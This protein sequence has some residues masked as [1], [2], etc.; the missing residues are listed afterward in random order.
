MIS[1]DIKA[2]EEVVTEELKN[3]DP[4]LVQAAMHL[5]NAGG[6]RLRPIMVLL[7]A[8]ATRED[9]VSHKGHQLLAMAVEI[10]HTATL[11]HDDIIDE[12]T[13]RRGLP[14]VNRKWGMRTSILTGDF[15]LARSCYYISV[16][17]KIRLNTIFSQMVM[18]MCNGEM[19]QLERRH[20]SKISYDEYLEQVRCKTAL[21]MAV[22]C[23]GAAI[24]NDAS[25]AEEKALYT[26][27]HDLGIAFQIMDDILDFSVSEK[28]M[29]KSAQ[30]DLAQGQVT[31]PTYYA[32]KSSQYAQE[33]HEM[34]A[35]KMNRE[36]DLAR[37]FEI[38]YESDGVKR[39]E[40]DARRFVDSALEALEILPQTASRKALAELAEFAIQRS[41]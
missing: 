27:G 8:R 17:E 11:I 31:L 33:L 15:L 4:T 21:L 35:R 26:F 3:Y 23:Q 39:A 28:S 6:K 2:L 9:Q 10:L 32:L 5:M 1:P 37:A 12:S 40:E 38:V 29:G 20:N 30:N 13:T 41:D 36:G 19:S 7:A 16:I 34:I 25:A 14:T 22:G 18:D 24:I